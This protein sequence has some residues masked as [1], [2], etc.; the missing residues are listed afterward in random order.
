MDLSIVLFTRDRKD[1]LYDR[2]KYYSSFNASLF[3]ADSSAEPIDEAEIA[4]LCPNAL[5]YHYDHECAALDKIRKTIS[6]VRTKYF[7]IVP[8]DDFF[9][10]EG[11]LACMRWLDD[12]PSYSAVQ[13]RW[14]GFCDEIRGKYVEVY[15][16]PNQDNEAETAVDR[17]Y[18]LWSNPSQW[19]YCVA[20]TNLIQINFDKLGNHNEMHHYCEVVVASVMVIS[21][22]AKIIP[23]PFGVGKIHYQPPYKPFAELRAES[24]AGIDNGWEYMEKDLSKLIAE[25]DRAEYGVV[26]SKVKNA[27]AVFCYTPTRKN[28]IIPWIKGYLKKLPIIRGQI[29]H[30]YFKKRDFSSSLKPP[31]K[32]SDLADIEKYIWK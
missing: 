6:K 29:V 4:S 15:T 26:R 2:L 30:S 28:N 21:G 22:K 3:V 13:G 18:H 9:C 1:S 11:V 19:F 7:M 24:I 12:N 16:E 25:I 14:I 31:F 8:D 20:R 32:K 10:L 27:F 17:F 23:V 5:Y